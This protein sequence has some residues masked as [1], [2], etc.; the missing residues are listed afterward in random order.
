M[1]FFICTIAEFAATWAA[2]ALPR[3]SISK[4]VVTSGKSE[5]SLW[6]LALV[7]KKDNVAAY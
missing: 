6:L 5:D 2:I 7:G 4:R 1:A 3:A